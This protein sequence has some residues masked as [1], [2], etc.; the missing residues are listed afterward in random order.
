MLHVSLPLLDFVMKGR[1]SNI[2]PNTD[3][4]CP[5]KGFLGWTSPQGLV[6]DRGAAMAA[7]EADAV[8]RDSRLATAYQIAWSSK[9]ILDVVV[10]G[11]RARLEKG[12]VAYFLWRFFGSQC[13]FVMELT[14]LLTWS[15]TN[16]VTFDRQV[17]NSHNATAFVA[18]VSWVLGQYLKYCVVVS[19]TASLS[20]PGSRTPLFLAPLLQELSWGP[21]HWVDHLPPTLSTLLHQQ[22]TRQ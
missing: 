13:P 2:D 1:F 21:Y 5:A 10:D 22:D 16:Q 12:T 17:K 4:E 20:D 14:G 18:D 6:S 11:R 7:T 9:V 8:A 15:K 3:P 19:T